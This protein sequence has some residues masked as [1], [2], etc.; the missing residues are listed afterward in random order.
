MRQS[1]EF[2]VGPDGAGRPELDADAVRAL[3]AAYDA[4]R[5]WAAQRRREMAEA[6][7]VEGPRDG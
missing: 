1:I 2:Q 6:G 7:H 3:C 5:V 4:L